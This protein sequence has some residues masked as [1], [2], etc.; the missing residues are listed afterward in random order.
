MGNAIAR[1]YLLMAVS[2]AFEAVYYDTADGRFAWGGSLRS[3]GLLLMGIYTA[4]ELCRMVKG[5]NE[6]SNKD[7]NRL[8][9]VSRQLRL[10]E[11]LAG[12]VAVCRSE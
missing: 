6:K 11:A 3:E 5:Y 12:S 9:S 4:P 8:P 2:Q 7:K 1:G 10:V